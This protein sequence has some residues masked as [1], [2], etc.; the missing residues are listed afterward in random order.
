M[1]S[2]WPLI[3]CKEHAAKQTG[4]AQLAAQEQVA[5]DVEGRTAQLAFVRID[6][7]ELP[8]AVHIV[9]SVLVTRGSGEIPPGR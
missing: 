2:H 6:N 3:H 5:R 1:L 7:P 9:F 4:L 8:T